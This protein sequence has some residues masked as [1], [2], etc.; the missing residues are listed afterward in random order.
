MILPNIAYVGGGGE[1]GYWL[2]LKDVFS[3]L[4]LS[5]PILVLRNSVLF[6]DKKQSK[7][8]TDLGLN[9]I[10]FFSE[11][12]EV[13]SKYIKATSDN[14]DISSH[15]STIND[16]FLS[17]SNNIKDQG[18]LRSLNALNQKTNNSLNDFEKK[19]IKNLKNIKEDKINQIN[20]LKALF[21]PENNLQERHDSFVMAYSKFGDNFIKNLISSLDPL[22]TN[23]VILDL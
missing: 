7:K 20:K 12:D 1:I 9:S 5:M 22:D 18:L 2:Q 17:I 13:I 23:F 19:I 8:L 3:D 6:I 14:I 11:S 15:I 4:S 16:G 10:D 21:F